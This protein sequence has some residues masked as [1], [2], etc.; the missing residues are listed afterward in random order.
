[1]EP[2]RTVCR[3][4]EIPEGE[5]RSFRLG[6]RDVAV[7]ND[8]GQFFAL[9]DRCP[10]AGASIGRGWVEDGS[11]V[12]PLHYWKFRLADGRCIA[13]GSGAIPRFPCEVRDGWIWVGDE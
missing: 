12:C 11:A 2:G 13:G 9:L 5:G 3:V 1:M 10:H 6:D 7:F 8:E 4:E